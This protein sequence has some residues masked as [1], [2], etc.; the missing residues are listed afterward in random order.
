M[1]ATE[2]LILSCVT[3]GEQNPEGVT[4]C[5]HCGGE[6]LAKKRSSG[7]G[8]VQTYSM[9]N[10][11]PVGRHKDRAP[12]VVAVV[13]TDEGM[14]V[15]AIVD[16][17]TPAEVRIGDDVTFRRYEKNVGFIFRKVE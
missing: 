12:Y 15:T 11:V 4:I 17:D 2:L 6:D 16:S 3:C 14:R 8:I 13:E 1:T 9:L 7:K 10:F 5:P